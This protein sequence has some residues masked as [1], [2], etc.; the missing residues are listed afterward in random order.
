MWIS[1]FIEQANRTNLPEALLSLMTRAAVDLG[2]DRYAYCALT[3][4]DRY[5]PGDK[6]APAIVLNFPTSWTDYYF[7]HGYQ[8]IDP[9]VVYA[10]EIEKPFLWDSLSP[11]FRLTPA[12]SLVMQ[13]AREARLLDGVGVPLH[14]PFGSVCLLTFASGD[15]HPNPR[16]ALGNLAVLSAQFHLAYTEIGR[17]DMYPRSAP[18][19]SERE[20]ECL[21]WI[22]N[23]KSSWD[24]GTILNI[25]ENTV[26]FHIKNAFRKLETNSRVV[27]VV[28]AIRYRLISP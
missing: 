13:Q 4:H 17:T 19:L 8:T 28:K 1:E 10:P 23:G 15:G 7:E 11:T 21:H 22:A 27:A 14:G 20:R 25:S 9:V 16:A 12:Q 26:N 5:I 6:P 2:F 24:V 3:G 18:V